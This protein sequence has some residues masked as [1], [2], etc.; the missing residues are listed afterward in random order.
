MS[1]KNF[2]LY[3]KTFGGK[4]WTFLHR[5]SPG[6]ILGNNFNEASFKSLR[7]KYLRSISC[8]IIEKW[9]PIYPLLEEKHFEQV[10]FVSLKRNSD[11]IGL[12]RTSSI[13]C[14]RWCVAVSN[15]RASWQTIQRPIRN[16][17][18]TFKIVISF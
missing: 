5:V 10:R 3:T 7:Q 2:L 17:K 6:N 15:E 18:F 16:M 11:S 14:T 4:I 1:G 9:T 8:K 12:S 13:L